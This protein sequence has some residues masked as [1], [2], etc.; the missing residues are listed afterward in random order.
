MSDFG[1]VVCLALA[2]PYLS[3]EPRHVIVQDRLMLSIRYAREE[4]EHTKT[5]LQLT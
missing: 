5:Y 4:L 3:M 2:L 1:K